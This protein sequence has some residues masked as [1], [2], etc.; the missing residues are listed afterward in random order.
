MPALA[1]STSTTITNFCT[2][3]LCALKKYAGVV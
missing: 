1:F 2:L 3:Y